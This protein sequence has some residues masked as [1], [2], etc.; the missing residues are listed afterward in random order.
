MPE[1]RNRAGSLAG[2]LRPLTAVLSGSGASPRLSGWSAR[3]GICRPA[4]APPPCCPGTDCQWPPLSSNPRRLIG[5]EV[6]AVPRQSLPSCRRGFTSLSPRP[7][8]CR[9]SRTASPRCAGALSQMTCSGPWCLSPSC[10]RKQAEVSRQE[11]S[12]SLDY[13]F[14]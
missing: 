11:L 12:R 2:V 1:A 3:P 5:V 4:P 6:R 14:N 13:L 9:Y 7:G 10:L 8:V